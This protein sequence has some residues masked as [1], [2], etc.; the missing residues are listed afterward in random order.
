MRDP[1]MGDM[2]GGRW[3]LDSFEDSYDADY[4]VDSFFFEDDQYRGELW[5]DLRGE[6]VVMSAYAVAGS[7]EFSTNDFRNDL[8]RDIDFNETAAFFETIGADP[9]DIVFAVREFIQFEI[10]TPE[11]EEEATG[12][13]FTT[14][15]EFFVPENIANSTFIGVAGAQ[16]PL[17][18][19]FD[20]NVPEGRDERALFNLNSSTGEFGFIEPPDFERPRDFDGDN[21]YLVH[22]VVTDGVSTIRD[23]KDTVVQ[24]LSATDPDLWTPGTGVAQESDLGDLLFTDWSQFVLVA[25]DGTIDFSLPASELNP[26]VPACN[27]SSGACLTLT[28]FQAFYSTVTDETNV[29]AQGSFTGLSV[30]GVQTSGTFGITFRPHPLSDFIINATPGAFAISTRDLGNSRFLTLDAED[31][32]QARDSSNNRIVDDIAVTVEH[33]ITQSTESNDTVLS[34]HAHVTLLGTNASNEIVKGAEIIVAMGRPNIAE[35]DGTSF[36]LTGLSPGI[37]ENTT[38][39][40]QLKFRKINNV[41]V[42]LVLN[43]DERPRDGDLFT[44]RDDPDCATSSTDSCFFLTPLFAF[45]FEDPRDQGNGNDLELFLRFFSSEGTEDLILKPTI[46]DVSTSDGDL[47]LS[48]F[49]QFFGGSLE[50]FTGSLTPVT[51]SWDSVEEGLPSVGVYT[52]DLDTS[53]LNQACN[54]SQ[55]AGYSTIKA[56]YDRHFRTITF[57]AT[58]TFSNTPS[59]GTNIS[60]TFDAYFSHHDITS[61]AS[62]NPDEFGTF[63]FTT[64]ASAESGV[65]ITTD[66]IDKIGFS[67]EGISLPDAV[68]VRDAGGNDVSSSV[69]LGLGFNFH[70]PAPEPIQ[71]FT[72]AHIKLLGSNS[73]GAFSTI[74]DQNVISLGAPTRIRN[75]AV[76]ATA[77]NSGFRT[78]N[79]VENTQSVFIAPET[80]IND[81]TFAFDVRGN[82]NDDRDLFE[83]N[84]E[85]GELTFK[86][87]PDFE[88]PTDRDG[89]NNLSV[90]TAVSDGLDTTFIEVIF[91]VTDVAAPNANI[92]TS[93]VQ[94]FTASV[95]TVV[96]TWEAYFALVGDGILTWDPDLSGISQV[97]SGSQC[98]DVNRFFVSY[99]TNTQSA[100]LQST[101]TFTNVPVAGTDTSGTYSVTF[102]DRAAADLV[103][104]QNPSTFA[105]STKNL[106]ASNVLLPDADDVVSILSNASAD[107]S[108]SVTIQASTHANDPT[109]GSFTATQVG[110]VSV[111][112][113]AANASSTAAVTNAIELGQPNVGTSVVNP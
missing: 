4:D 42:S 10:E 51:D 77:S 18:F 30:A 70:G 73:S 108:A 5:T 59:L 29:S 41:P 9:N 2:F 36:F 43:P 80:N 47:N 7:D 102:S 49:Q 111:S 106:G 107:V 76:N 32:F 104:I 19:S 101:G 65:G 15:A 35:D 89:N 57:R 8:I 55:C 113:T 50:N 60:G 62:A 39:P 110:T 17:T 61:F 23:V 87:A 53:S 27:S 22:L 83:L 98:L 85:T 97:C 86:T 81:L 103:S 44:V 105:F 112:G 92:F 88:N 66:K 58:G 33:R 48:D 64:N 13:R 1:E 71:A 14:N 25:Q 26:D 68:T 109:S 84:T 6:Q 31:D 34:S 67:F 24:N 79:I 90:T 46:L 54:G 40:I 72:V 37:K 100:T 74:V 82:A 56:Q 63:N 95:D 20:P 78:E 21:G 52:W 94:A 12:L 99:N 75:R 69:A 45:D 16:G 93:D 91:N 3:T 96:D 28:L 38:T 11:G